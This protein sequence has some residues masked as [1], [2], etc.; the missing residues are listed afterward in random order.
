MP[1]T[2]DSLPLHAS[3][4]LDKH[5]HEKILEFQSLM[6]ERTFNA[7]N[8]DRRIYVFVEPGTNVKVD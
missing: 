7:Y 1:T 2:F 4:T 5:P 3:F 8:F 6:G